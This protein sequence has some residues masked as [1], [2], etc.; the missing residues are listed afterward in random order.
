MIRRPPRSTLF[1][2]TTL[3]RS[4]TPVMVAAGRRHLYDTRRT[5]GLGQASCASCHVDG[6]MDR[7]GWD[8]G[9]PAGAVTTA[10]VNSQGTLVVN[11]YHPMKGVML[12]Q[13]L[14]DIIGHEPFHWR[15]DKPDI[16]AFNATFTNLQAAATGLT[17]MEMRAL[18]DFLKSIRFPPNP[19]RNFDNSLSTSL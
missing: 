5:S 9:N 1:P 19:Y 15:G 16:E 17:T 14:Q 11:V 10:L 2:Y 6:R 3:F 18:R 12:T 13:T 7:L 4:P 8:L